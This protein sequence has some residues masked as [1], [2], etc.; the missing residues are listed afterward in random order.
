MKNHCVTL[1]ETSIAPEN[2]YL[3]TIVSFSGGL[4]SWQVRTVSFQEGIFLSL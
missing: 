3:K 2:G 1:P 4:A